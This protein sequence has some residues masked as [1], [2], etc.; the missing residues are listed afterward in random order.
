MQKS[1][2]RTFAQARRLIAEARRLDLSFRNA[3]L[4]CAP[5]RSSTPLAHQ[6]RQHNP[7]TQAPLQVRRLNAFRRD[8]FDPAHLCFGR[9]DNPTH[10]R[11]GRWDNPAHSV[12]ARATRAPKRSVPG[13]PTARNGGASVGLSAGSKTEVRRVKNV[14][15]IYLDFSADLDLYDISNVISTFGS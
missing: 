4:E 12:S 6:P 7:P 15:P 9:W 14:P 8:I 5:T 1:Q 2:S 3:T 11:F 10:L 13:C